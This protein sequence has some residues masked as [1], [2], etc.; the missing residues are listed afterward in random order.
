MT[1]IYRDIMTVGQ[2]DRE[3]ADS[4]TV[5]Q[6]DSRT[7]RQYKT[8]LGTVRWGDSWDSMTETVAKPWTVGQ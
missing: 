2:C 4:K 5:Q 3:T 7:G 6:R 1:D 8:V